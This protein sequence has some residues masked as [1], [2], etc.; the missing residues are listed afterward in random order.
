MNTEDNSD[1]ESSSDEGDHDLAMLLPIEKANAETDMDSDISDDMNDGLVHHL[2]RRLLN[3]TCDSILLDKENKQ[4]YVQRTQPPIKKSRKSAARN[5]KKG[6]DLQPTL[7]LSE[8]NAVPE[9]WKE[10]IKSPTGAFKPM[11]WFSDD[12]VLHVTNQANLYAVQHGKGNLNIL[13]DEI[14]TFIVALLLSG[15][16]KVPYRNLY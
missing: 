4:K 3:S 2:P 10:I 8:E 5:W 13:E 6:T 15:Y 14:R 11:T 7:R 9:E 12:L 1:I 16:W